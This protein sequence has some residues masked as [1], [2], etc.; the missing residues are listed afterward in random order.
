M[1]NEA[2]ILFNLTLL[3]FMVS[4]LYFKALKKDRR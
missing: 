3:D 4:F 1:R 2:L